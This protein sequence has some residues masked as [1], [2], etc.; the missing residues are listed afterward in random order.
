MTEQ[1][2]IFKNWDIISFTF[3]SWLEFIIS[4]LLLTIDLDINDSL[5]F[6]SSITEL[7]LFSS[8][9]SLELNEFFSWLSLLIEI[10]SISVLIIK[11]L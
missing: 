8:S 3:S 2:L 4:L 9:N 6:S 1:F 10:F 7:F 11:V 5:S